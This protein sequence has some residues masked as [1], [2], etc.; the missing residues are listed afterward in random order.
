ME[1]KVKDILGQVA[2]TTLSK[3]VELSVDI[4]PR[5]KIHRWLQTKKWRPAKRMLYI[6]PAFLGTLIRISKLLLS[7]D[8]A[9]LTKDNLLD[10]NYKLAR[11]HG[12]KMAMIIAAAVH[13]RESEP[14]DKLVE[15]ITWNFS[16]VELMN[17]VAIVTRQLGVTS[18]MSS[19][20]SMK[21]LNVLDSE[22][23]KNGKNGVSPME[24]GRSIAPGSK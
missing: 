19:I 11:E 2:D 15:F 6:H 22:P 18:F 23:R 10:G 24:Q 1:E 7:I 13:N 5:N 3:A 4:R 12:H 16:T 14:P 9:V 21:G 8:L 20:I 17:V